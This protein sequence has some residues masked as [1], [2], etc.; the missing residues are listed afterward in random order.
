LVSAKSTTLFTIPLLAEHSPLQLTTSLLVN[1]K[2]AFI[3]PVAQQSETG[4]TFNAQADD[5]FAQR[6]DKVGFFGKVEEGRVCLD[7]RAVVGLTL[8]A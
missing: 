2:G 5:Q 6:S 3:R 7:A 4:G 1:S 8:E